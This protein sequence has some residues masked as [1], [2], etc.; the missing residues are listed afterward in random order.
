MTR[1]G[2]PGLEVPV[3]RADEAERRLPGLSGRGSYLLFL[4]PVALGLLYVR[5]YGVNVPYNDGWTLVPL[6]ENLSLGTLTLE[7]LFKQHNEHRTLFPRIAVLALGTVTGFNDVANMYLVQG[8][9]FI[10]LVLLLLAFRGSV[11]TKPLLFLPI[12]FM[13]FSLNQSW[14]MLQGFQITLVFV[15][16]FA[17]L[18]FY[19]L[20][21][22]EYGRFKGLAFAGSL[23]GAA[24]STFSSAPGL[25]VWPAGLVQLLLQLLSRP[26]GRRAKGLP[27]V[28][29][30]CLAGALAW[31]TYFR[32]YKGTGRISL[33]RSA[34]EW[35]ASLKFLVS[36]LGGALFEDQGTILACGVLIVSLSVVALIL[37]SRSGT[38]GECSFWVAL[39]CFAFLVASGTSVARVDN[40]EGATDPKFVTY[41]V[42]TPIACYTMLAAAARELRSPVG[43]APFGVLVVLLAA[44]IPLSYLTGLEEG[45]EI[46][47]K[48]RPTEF[49]LSTYETQPGEVLAS[50]PIFRENLCTD[51]QVSR[52]RAAFLDR[53]G[54]SVFARPRPEVLPP[55]LSG[56]SHVP[57]EDASKA[58]TVKDFHANRLDPGVSRGGPFMTVTGR[59]TDGPASGVYV[60]V[61]GRP[62]PAFYGKTTGGVADHMGLPAYEHSGFER[63]MP[64]S[65]IGSG[66]HKLSIVVVTDDGRAYRGADRHIDFRVGSGWHGACTVEEH[67]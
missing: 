11:S 63:S 32:G 28:F 40:V 53:R 15:Q 51:P 3:G 44:S 27:R 50:P 57:E 37:S 7:D 39:L 47:Q 61:D 45:A 35:A 66:S 30:W 21:A 17:V 58:P 4:L 12:P 54:Y 36:A 26:R 1:G 46:E 62:F 29:G 33:Q 48:K 6:F 41:L 23:G 31:A 18:A 64:L 67:V 19:L 25:A 38:L 13:V 16:T 9:L 5:L 43:Y 42:L 14:N 49:V 60:V 10:T 59:L 34:E 52:R 55:P 2:T 65:E 22:S 8:C 56:L 20:R 24:V